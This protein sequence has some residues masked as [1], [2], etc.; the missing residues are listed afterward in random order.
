MILSKLIVG[1]GVV[2]LVGLTSLGFKEK[3]REPAQ[4]EANAAIAEEINNL[5][6]EYRKDILE[7]RNLQ[8]HQSICSDFP[9]LPEC[10]DR[11]KD[12]KKKTN[13]N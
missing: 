10:M 9:E 5:P 12:S 13:T 2:G 11:W 7:I 8:E 6:E 1:V 3:T 4:F